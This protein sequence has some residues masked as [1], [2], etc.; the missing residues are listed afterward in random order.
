MIR[1]LKLI[2][3]VPLITA[4]IFLG[5]IALFGFF[6]DTTSGSRGVSI[7]IGVIAAFTFLVGRRLTSSPSGSGTIESLMFSG[8]EQALDTFEFVQIS[9]GGKI[10]VIASNATEAKFAVKELRLL[11]KSFALQKRAILDQQK[12]I[13][14][15]YTHHVRRRGS[16]V[17]GG[18]GLGR[19]VRIVQS[20]G[21]DSTRSQLARQLQ[22]LENEIQRLNHALTHI[23]SLIVQVESQ[24]LRVE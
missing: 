8:T 14:A 3:G 10:S 18:G 5:A 16:M 17:R 15:N 13:R 7:T 23:D 22:P 19:F 6:Y 12:E 9:S 4:G 24:S 2:L 20:A 11:R 1:L 21:R